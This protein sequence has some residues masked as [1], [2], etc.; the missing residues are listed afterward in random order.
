MIK[1]KL[2]LEELWI[3]ASPA[4]D[5]FHPEALRPL[6]QPA[7]RYIEHAIAPGTQLASA[8]RLRMH[9]EIKLGKWLPFT[10]E[11]VIR[12]ER[13][14]IWSATVHKSGIPIRG[15]DRVVDREGSMQ[16]KL[17]GIFPMM[18][19]SGSDITR[20]VIGRLQVESIWL[21]SMFCRPD[22]TWT[23]TAE[24]CPHAHFT[25][26]GETAELDLSV[27]ETGRVKTAALP[28]W[29]NPEGGAFHF[30]QFGGVL[31]E[32]R[33]FDGYTIPSRIRAGWYFGTDRFSTDGEF[34]RA[35]IDEAIF[36]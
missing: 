5:V 20:S 27:D 12:Q 6:P 11:Q 7:K 16:W 30:V 17:F 4:G 29:G 28:R 25:V 3:A 8:V 21:P 9:G 18:K 1:N 23:E 22:V 31:E 36:R 32:E 10:A 13:G 35:V 33:I 26:Q 2:S 34:F 24:S 19:A 15:S 14:M